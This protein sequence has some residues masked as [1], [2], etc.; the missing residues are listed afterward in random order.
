MRQQVVTTANGVTCIGY[1]NMPS[2]MAATA[3]QL[4]SGNVTKLLLSMVKDEKY[5]VDLEDTA[6]RSML[7]VHEGTSA[8]SDHLSFL[9][10]AG[11]KLDPYV[12]PPPPPP[13]PQQAVVTPEDEEVLNWLRPVHC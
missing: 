10:F 5:V 7:V 4:F 8:S 6:V 13:P 9:R 11:A 12:P 2:R 1:T 3:S